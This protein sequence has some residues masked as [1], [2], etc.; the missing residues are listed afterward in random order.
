M[1]IGH[2]SSYVDIKTH[3]ICKTVVVVA[4]LNAEVNRSYQVL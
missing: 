3:E 1:Y 4:E 2:F